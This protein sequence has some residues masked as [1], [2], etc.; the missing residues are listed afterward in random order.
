MKYIQKTK[1]FDDIHLRLCKTVYKQNKK[2][3]EKKAAFSPLQ[4]G[5]PQDHNEPQ[6]LLQ[7]LLKFIMLWYS[8]IS[9]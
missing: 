4:E 3:I 1:N 2:R 9:N 6:L 8:T 7:K 5:R